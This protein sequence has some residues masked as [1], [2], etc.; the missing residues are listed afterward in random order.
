[1][2]FR[3]G[4]KVATVITEAL[5]LSLSF[6]LSLSLFLSLSLSLSPL[7]RRAGLAAPLPLRGEKKSADEDFAA[8][9]E[10]RSVLQI[11]VWKFRSAGKRMG[12]SR[13]LETHF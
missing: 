7:L 6:S 10:I 8:F 5:S 9:R 1:M 11:I 2:R 3:H 12:R 13:Q 4:G